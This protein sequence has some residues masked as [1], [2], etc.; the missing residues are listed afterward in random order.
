MQLICPSSKAQVPGNFSSLKQ[1]P[2]T[3]YDAKPLNTEA[4]VAKLWH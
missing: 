2:D 4:I 1:S 3:E